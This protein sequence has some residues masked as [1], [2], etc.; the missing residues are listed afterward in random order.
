MFAHEGTI[1]VAKI[2]AH[3]ELV[4][5]LLGNQKTVDPGSGLC[6]FLN[7]SQLLRSLKLLFKRLAKGHRV[8]AQQGW[9]WDQTEFCAGH[10]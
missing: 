5:L 4:I 6:T 8:G 7:D 3:S 1:E 9:H 10:L 2:Q